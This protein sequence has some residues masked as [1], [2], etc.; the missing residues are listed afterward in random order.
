MLLSN[1]PK[2]LGIVAGENM[3]EIGV[4]PWGQKPLVGRLA[5]HHPV[6]YPMERRLGCKCFLTTGGS[7]IKRSSGMSRDVC[8]GYCCGSG[9]LLLASVGSGQGCWWTSV[10]HTTV[11]PARNYLAALLVGLRLR[12]PSPGTSSRC[13]LTHYTPVKEHG[14]FLRK[15]CLSDSGA[16]PSCVQVFCLPH[17]LEPVDR[18]VHLVTRG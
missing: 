3:E 5:P 17:G 11:L 4:E 8:D 13:I 15:F 6:P 7:V 10:M 1:F 12:L 9:G 18:G 14:G 2:T 16:V